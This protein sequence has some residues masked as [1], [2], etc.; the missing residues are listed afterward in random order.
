MDDT[1]ICEGINSKGFGII[2]KMVMQDR[3]LCI[4]AKGLY[5]YFCS[6]AGAGD[7]CFPTRKKICYDLGIAIDTFG[8]YLKQLIARGYIKSEQIKENGRFSHNVYTLCSTVAPC[9]EK[10]V[11]E[12]TVYEKSYTNNNSNK[13]NNNNKNNSNR[14]KERKATPKEKE[15]TPIATPKKETYNEIIET[16]TSNESLQSELKAFLQLRKM[17]N[18][19][20]TNRGLRLLLETL[21]KLAYQ[22]YHKTAIVKKALANGWTSFKPLTDSEAEALYMEHQI[23][24][25]YGEDFLQRVMDDEII[26]RIA[27]GLKLGGK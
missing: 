20:L 21:D 6:Y 5:S 8:K 12:N 23:S 7:S 27:D 11:T 13:N 16:Y 4:G 2:P 3:E 17:K 25:K 26:G 10:P 15:K 9:T 14:S 18:A 24:A 1:L 19:P 22:D